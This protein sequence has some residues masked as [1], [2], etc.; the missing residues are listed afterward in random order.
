MFYLWNEYE[1]RQ[2]NI[3]HEKR[4]TNFH[5]FRKCAPFSIG[6]VLLYVHFINGNW[7]E[8]DPHK[9]TLYTKINLI[10]NTRW[11]ENGKHMSTPLVKAQFIPAF[12]LTICAIYQLES[13]IVTLLRAILDVFPSFWLFLCQCEWFWMFVHYFKCAHKQNLVVYMS[14]A[15]QIAL[16]NPQNQPLHSVSVLIKLQNSSNG[17]LCHF[18]LAVLDFLWF[19]SRLSHR[20]NKKHAHF[21]CRVVLRICHLR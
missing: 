7:I 14:T 17:I 1:Q 4:A 3:L 10:C 11:V 21:K 6:K 8:C 19:I 13:K 5:F 9:I 16:E 20:W 18:L 2:L 15:T 12:F